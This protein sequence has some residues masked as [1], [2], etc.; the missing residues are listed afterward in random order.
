MARPA[1]ALIGSFEL[2]MLLSFGPVVGAAWTR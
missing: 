2:L 1:V